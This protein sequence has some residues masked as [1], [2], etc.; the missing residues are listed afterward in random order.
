MKINPLEQLS[1]YKFSDEGWGFISSIFNLLDNISGMGEINLPLRE[2]GIFRALRRIWRLLTGKYSIFFAIELLGIENEGN[3]S[4]LAWHDKRL[5]NMILWAGVSAFLVYVGSMLILAILEISF[6]QISDF[7]FTVG[8][9]FVFFF[10]LMLIFAYRLVFLFMK[11][12]YADTICLMNTLYLLLEL[13]HPE[14][15]NTPKHR[16]RIQKRMQYLANGVL[17][18][19]QHYESTSSENDNYIKTHF[20]AMEEFGLSEN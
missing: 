9:L 10:Y 13:F 17:L 18:L 7:L 2:S 6:P 20:H 5:R 3:R 4:I 14:G 8:G 11:K 12:D 1:Q 15:I 19:S 16:R